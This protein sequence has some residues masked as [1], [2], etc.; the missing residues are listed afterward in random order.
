MASTN[1]SITYEMLEE[2]TDY[3]NTSHEYLLS[4]YPDNYKAS[5]ADIVSIE[6]PPDDNHYVFLNR[7][8]RVLSAQTWGNHLKNYFAEC[9]IPVDSTVKHNN[10]SHRLR[11]GFAMFH[12]HFVEPQKRADVFKLK[13]MMRH[14][15]ISST[16]K[17]YNPTQEDQYKIKTEFQD[18]LY[19]MIPE[20]RGDLYVE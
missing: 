6:D 18:E 16:Y 12:A 1:V 5:S 19:K 4:K 3:I 15:S 10:L 2:L 20:L 14:R 9:K 13:K 7:Y 11:H 8:G 17:Y